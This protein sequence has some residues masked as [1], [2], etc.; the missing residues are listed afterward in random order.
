MITPDGRTWQPAR[1]C[2]HLAKR[3]PAG[4]IAVMIEPRSMG[5]GAGVPQ[6]LT[7]PEAASALLLTAIGGPL[8]PRRVPLEQALG[9]VLAAPLV[10]AEPVPDRPAA[11]RDGWAVPA[12][13]TLGAGPYAP[14]PLS[15]APH[16]VSPGEPMPPGTDAVLPPFDLDSEGPLPQA[17][18]ALAPGEGVRRPG[19]EI[20]AGCV[21]RSA[22]ERLLA[23]DLPALA[24]LG[25]TSAMVRAPRLAWITADPGLD[26]L[27]PFI[28]ALAR[29][30]GASLHPAAP[31]A[32][33]AGAIAA[34]L[35]AA[36]AGHDLVLLAGGTGEGPEDHAAAGLSEAGRL[37]FHGIG[38]LPGMATG[39]G[40]V[41]GRP[42][43]LLP[44][45]AEDA[46]AAWILLVGPAL[47]AMTGAA[48]APPLRLR[49]TRKVASTV[50]LA[51]LV[52]LRLDGTGGAE[53]LAV[54]ALPLAALSA[55]AA[56]LLVPPGT[57]G[58]E[59]GTDIAA[60]AL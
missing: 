35:R 11:A 49:L 31:V 1:A 41:E 16:R 23:R 40:I 39:A 60:Q 54:G 43:L 59:A 14:A 48:T 15:R 51:E 58:Y 18:A 19:E 45:R 26:T 46:I 52:P 8:A 3:E 17:L 33:N 12:M 20:A 6:R 47:D 36:A 44:G 56:I 50:G 7:A 9:L 13:E 10:A 53:P 2:R 55:A 5:E 24:A 4:H 25:I 38:A 30:A 29:E 57:E 37:L 34:A 21:L 28:A 42:V 22:G 27:R 32:A